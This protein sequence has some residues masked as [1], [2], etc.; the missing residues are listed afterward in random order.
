MTKFFRISSMKIWK[1]TRVHEMKERRVLKQPSLAFVFP[2]QKITKPGEALST[3]PPAWS[4][5]PVSFL[6]KVSGGMRWR[7]NPVFSI[8]R[9]FRT[10]IIIHEMTKLAICLKVT[11]WLPT[12]SCD[13]QSPSLFWTR[14]SVANFEL[15]YRHACTHPIVQIWQCHT[16]MIVTRTVFSNVI[17]VSYSLVVCPKNSNATVLKTLRRRPSLKPFWNSK[18]QTFV[19]IACTVLPELTCINPMT[20]PFKPGMHKMQTFYSRIWFQPWR[21]VFINCSSTSL[22]LHVIVT[23]WYGFRQGWQFTWVYMQHT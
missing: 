3:I 1:C 16:T 13:A 17:N 5:S 23:F 18:I 6:R 7:E 21:Y 2:C 19:A 4:R 10:S 20:K 15:Q 14:S 8:L 12:W 9:A 11:D 22:E